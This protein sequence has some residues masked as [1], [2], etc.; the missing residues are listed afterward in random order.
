[1]LIASREGRNERGWWSRVLPLGKTQRTYVPRGDG[2]NGGWVNEKGLGFAFANLDGG[3]TVERS[4]S[5]L[6][7]Y[8]KEEGLTL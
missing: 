4:R 1:M 7:L 2:K 8:G 6:P 5:V 3:G